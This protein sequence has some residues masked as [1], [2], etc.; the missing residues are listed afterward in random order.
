MFLSVYQSF[1]RRLALQK[2]KIKTKYRDSGRIFSS[3][4][5]PQPTNLCTFA[6]YLKNADVMHS[7]HNDKDIIQ[8]T[9][10]AIDFLLVNFLLLGTLSICK[11]I[12]PTPFAT[13]WHYLFL[14]A[15]FAMVVG[16]MFFRTIIHTRIIAAGQIIR[17]VAA[18]TLTQSAIMFIC[19]KFMNSE[20]ALFTFFLYY[21]PVLFFVLLGT[22][23]IER[24]ALRA[25][26]L[27]GGNTR[28]VIFVGSDLANLEMYHELIAD[29]ATGYR[30]L[31]YYSNDVIRHAPKEFK[32][33]GS[34]ADM[35]KLMQQTHNIKPCDEL[36][37][38]LSHDDYKE[39]ISIMSFCD[40][41]I[42]HFFYIPRQFGNYRLQLKSIRFGDMD[43]FTNHVE[44]LLNPT[45][46]FI[47]R[48]FDFVVSLIVC[49][50]MLPFIPII[51]LI[52]KIQS[53]GPIF[54]KQKRTG[55][56]GK[57]FV[58]YK[59]RSMHINNDADKEQATKDDP[60]KF[61]FGN[62]MRKWNI[63]EFPQFFNVLK[64]DMSIV[65][66]RPHMLFHTDL[67][68]KVIDKYM[69]RHFSKPGITGWA[70]VTGYRGE[71]KELWQME[72]RIRRDIWYIEHWS[73]WLDIKIIL[74]TARSMFKSDVKAY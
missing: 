7:I 8:W 70:Q 26:R 61:A 69:V 49:L 71:T 29:A 64:N 4:R 14:A 9:V 50:I 63:D 52:I 16:E 73:F 60:R 28:T 67:Y 10:V 46:R 21:I 74:L 31:G 40:K 13:S 12:V 51:A 54:F 55:I 37:C 18:L 53:P 59:F 57:T 68:S 20:A 43:I 30:V 2:Y 33:L 22:R 6:Q 44:P 45:N 34:I 15:N 19:M 23:F 11:D 3:F 27:H 24:Q 36:F 65:G 58:C 66:P 72:E 41:H 56:N 42:I 25:Y 62:F 5:F 32:K 39:I 17:R 48:A 35:N 1:H 47:K 38:S